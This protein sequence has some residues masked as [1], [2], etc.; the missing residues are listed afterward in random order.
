[1]I[2]RT[3]RPPR[4]PAGR[5]PPHDLD[6]ERAVISTLLVGTPS[7]VSGVLAMLEPSD[8]YG[9]NHEA[10]FAAARGLVER[11]E[12]TDAVTMAAALRD[13]GKIGVAPMAYIAEI[14]DFVPSVSRWHDYAK[15]VLAMSTARRAIAVAQT[16]AAEGYG[17][18]GDRIAWA[19]EL[20]ARVE[21]SIRRDGWTQERAHDLKSLLLARW[22]E[23]D[24]EARA[25]QD[26]VLSWQHDALD[27][28]MGRWRPGS[29]TVI[30]ARSHVGKSSLARQVA[31]RLARQGHGVL[32]WSG[33]QPA[34]ECADAMMSQAARVRSGA[35]DYTPDEV[36]KISRFMKVTLDACA[37]IEIHDQPRIR[38]PQLKRL[39]RAARE[40]YAANGH[41]LRVVVVDYVQL[42]SAEGLELSRDATSEERLGAISKYLKADVAMGERVALIV[43]AQLNKDA[44]KRDGIPR[45]A[46]MRGSSA[47]EQDADKIILLHNPDAIARAQENRNDAPLSGESLETC[48]AIFGKARQGGQLGTVPLPFRPLFGRFELSEV[49][50]GWE[51]KSLRDK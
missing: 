1:M 9:E 49:P 33:E 34:E 42:M 43:A 8:F 11:G 25:T 47:I 39:V 7:A 36:E 41:A 45:T 10:M 51:P 50:R 40:R 14:I 4:D 16:I 35:T 3:K 44:D 17:D 20:P 2:D 46:D 31:M 12:Q 24:A 13:A 21:A 28:C 26:D 38:G 30:A 19:S 23:I 22:N 15:I 37:P 48:F 27:R 29:M 5:L 18:V 32:V 6:A